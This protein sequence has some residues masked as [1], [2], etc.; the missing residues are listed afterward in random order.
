[1]KQ[2]L[3]FLTLL[4]TLKE[5]ELDDFDLFLREEHP[6]E[7]IALRVFGYY[8]KFF[9][10]KELPEKMEVSFA[11]RK[12][13]KREPRPGLTDLKTVWNAFHKLHFWLKEYLIMERLKSDQ[14]LREVTWMQELAMRRV[15]DEYLKQASVSY[16]TSYRKYFDYETCQQFLELG[17]HYKQRFILGRPIPDYKSIEQCVNQVK[18]CADLISLK[19]QCELLTIKSVRPTKEDYREDESALNPMSIIYKYVSLMLEHR[20]EEHYARLELLINQYR[21][22][23]SMSDANDILR[24]VQN[25]IARMMREKDEQY[26]R[27]KLNLNFK[28]LL[29]KNFYHKQNPIPSAFFQNV[30]NIACSVGDLPWANQF[31][32]EFGDF[33]TSETKEE[34]MCVANAMIAFEQ[35]NFDKVILLTADPRIKD[36]IHWLRARSL[37]LRAM[38]E[39]GEDLTT[40]FSVFFTYLTRHKKP[41][42]PYKVSTFAF[43]EVFN[44]LIQRKLPREAIWG[45]LEQQKEVFFRSW[46]Q[47]KIKR[48]RPLV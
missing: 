43:M 40:D 33:L 15:T 44:M 8:K 46:L 3:K 36:E 37:Q 4:A 47:D 10:D 32:T 41:I 7:S 30:V 25:F 24:Y 13:F 45:A 14:F 19:L 17:K 20:Q 38:Y 39:L 42:T 18:E 23:I 48:Y 2:N 21:G 1:M 31:V 9:P 6:K 26:W 35:N 29:D 27:N 16:H 28:M 12:I 34:N 5:K 11:F 22:D